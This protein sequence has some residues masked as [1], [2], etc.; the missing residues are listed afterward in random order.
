MGQF[1]LPSVPNFRVVAGEPGLVRL[2]WADYPVA[3]KE[4]HRLLGF[5]LYRSANKDELGELIADESTLAP[6]VFRFDDTDSQAGPN[7]HYVCVAVEDM[8]FGDAPFGAGPFG[9]PSSNGFSLFPFNQRPLGSPVRG[10]G[11]SPFGIE[12]YGY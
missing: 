5:R 2:T 12:G 10:Y 9:E 1:P 6:N 11:Q 8:G 3:Q 4:G 7:R